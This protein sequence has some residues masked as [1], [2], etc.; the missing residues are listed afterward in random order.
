MSSYEDYVIKILRKSGLKFEREKTFNDLRHGKFRFDFFV[1]SMNAI[2]E[3]DGQQHF[4]RIPK[5]HKTERDFK[6]ALEY[7]RR[8]NSYCLAKDI[9]LYRI[10]YWEINEIKSVNDLFKDKFKV[11]TRWHNDNLIQGRQ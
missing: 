10:P 5:F 2:I 1:P 6:K 3:V 7:D 8:K 9:T 4:H 11:R